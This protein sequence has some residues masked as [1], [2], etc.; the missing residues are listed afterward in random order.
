MMWLMKLGSMWRKMIRPSVQPS[1]R[2][3]VT[4]S[5]VR[6]ERKRPRTTRA[7]CA[8][9]VSDRITVIMKYCVVAGQLCGIAA[10]S[11]SQIGMFGI[12]STNSITRWTA[13]SMRPP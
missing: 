6:S 7:S 11:A 3:A 5:S 4:N 10:E 12:A 8:Q 2:A 9:P 1:S 13:K